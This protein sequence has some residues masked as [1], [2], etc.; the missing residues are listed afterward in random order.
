[1]VRLRILIIQCCESEICWVETLLP[2]LNFGLYRGLVICSVI[3]KRAVPV[4]HAIMIVNDGHSTGSCAAKMQCLAVR[5]LH[6]FPTHGGFFGG[7]PKKHLF[8][9]EVELKK[10]RGWNSDTH[11]SPHSTNI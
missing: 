6:V 5:Y 8:S 4:T 7:N 11:P 10:A 9:E 3:A 1:M 2:I